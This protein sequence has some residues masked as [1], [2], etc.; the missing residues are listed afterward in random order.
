MS[1]REVVLHEKDRKFLLGTSRD[2]RLRRILKSASSNSSR[3][4]YLRISLTVEEQEHLVKV[5]AAILVDRGVGQDGDLNSV[6]RRLEALIDVF[7]P[8]DRST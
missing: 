5:L 4:P 7:N 2:G 6:G 8:Q 1:F 3:P